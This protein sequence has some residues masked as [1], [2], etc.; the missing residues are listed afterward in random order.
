MPTGCEELWSLVK[1]SICWFKKNSELFFKAKS[2]DVSDWV[3]WDTLG[4]DTP[5]EVIED[6]NINIVTSEVPDVYRQF[7]S[8][9]LI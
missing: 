7:G 9:R 5:V 4:N 8:T 1:A 2:T 3:E 6:V